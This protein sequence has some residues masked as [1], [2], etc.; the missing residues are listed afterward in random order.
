MHISKRFS[1]G[2]KKVLVDIDET[3]SYYPEE[4]QYDKAEPIIENIAKIN[5]LAEDGWNITYWTARGSVSR[6]D[7]YEFTVD[8]LKS[9]GCVFHDLIVGYREGP[10]CLPSKPHFDMVIDD[11]AKRIEEI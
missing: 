4:R 2:Q 9:W 7:Y 6:K 8:Q 10:F 3:I 1:E 11:K 5:Q